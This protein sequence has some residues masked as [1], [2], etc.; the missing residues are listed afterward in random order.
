MRSEASSR[1]YH[2]W[3]SRQAMAQHRGLLTAYQQRT[4]KLSHTYL[5]EGGLM[6]HQGIGPWTESMSE[7]MGETK[8]INYFVDTS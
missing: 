5:G 8:T 6:L 1:V 4:W 3:S 7:S 2:I